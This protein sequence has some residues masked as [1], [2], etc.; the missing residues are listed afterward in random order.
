MPRRV[1]LASLA[2]VLIA[3]TA[4]GGRPSTADAQSLAHVRAGAL[5]PFTDRAVEARQ[6]PL[7]LARQRADSAGNAKSTYVLGG[8]LVGGLVGALLAS[9]FHS[10]FCGDPSPGVSCSST[11]TTEGVLIGAGVGALVG[12]LV[13]S[14]THAERRTWRP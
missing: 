7:P 4:V 9:S 6:S 14:V 10:E 2:I 5:T 8:M 12:W 13:W 3:V 11:G 1:S